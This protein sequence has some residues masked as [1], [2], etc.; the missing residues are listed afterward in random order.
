MGVMGGRGICNVT[1]KDTTGGKVKNG[2]LLWILS[3][4]HR[5]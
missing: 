1:G 5:E 2:T 3:E 4:R